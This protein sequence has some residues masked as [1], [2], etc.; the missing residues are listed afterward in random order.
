MSTATFHASASLPAIH[1]DAE[2]ARLQGQAAKVRTEAAALSVSTDD[3]R[4]FAVAYLGE[5]ATVKKA[6]EARRVAL[7]KPLND[8]VG[9]VNAFVKAFLLPVEEADKL[10]RGRVLTYQQAQAAK[11]EAERKRQEDIRRAAEEEARRKEDEARRKLE[12]AA[13]L[14]GQDRAKAQAAMDAA[15]QAEQEAIAHRV[16]AAA[17]VVAQPVP[18]KT[19]STALGAATVRKT[20]S[21]R[22]VDFNKVP[23]EYLALDTAKVTTAIREGTRVI[24][25]LEI[26]QED[27]LSVRR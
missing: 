10:L 4:D 19:V 12:E 6:A 22:V 17:P 20:W 26:F 5:I 11:V 3:E 14:E 24:A 16:E 1:Q 9:S 23:I 13:R 8:H 15:L 18:A 7:V 2:L 25:G 27:S 21:Y